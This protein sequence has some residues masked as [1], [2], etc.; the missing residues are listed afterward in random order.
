MR[1]GS[2][3]AAARSI[4]ARSAARSAAAAAAGGA[5]AQLALG[6]GGPTVDTVPHTCC[7][8]RSRRCCRQTSAQRRRRAW[9]RTACREVP[10]L[11]FNGRIWCH[12][13]IPCARRSW[14]CCGTPRRC[15][16]SGA[17]RRRRR[18]RR[19]CWRRCA[20]RRT[21]WPAAAAAAPRTRQPSSAR[22]SRRRACR[23]RSRR[24]GLGGALPGFAGFPAL[25]AATLNPS[26]WLPAAQ[27]MTASK[28]R[29]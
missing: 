13:G 24:A 21:D 26:G 23:W 29:L 4:A 1:S 10:E 22:A 3:S 19:S 14:R 12:P 28:P 9:P 7:T 20:R 15:R 2:D 18:R 5:P 6:R 16:R 25:R 17:P 11:G 27:H 8:C